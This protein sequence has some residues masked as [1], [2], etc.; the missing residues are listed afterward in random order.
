LPVNLQVMGSDPA[1][2]LSKRMKVT[3]TLGSVEMKRELPD[4]K[5]LR[6][7]EEGS[8]GYAV[9][10]RGTKVMTFVCAYSAGPL[11]EALPTSAETKTASGSRWE[12]HWST[13]GAIDLSASKD[14]RWKELE[15]RIVLSQFFFYSND[16]EPIHVHV[17]K[18]NGEAVFHCGR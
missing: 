16:Y 10:A 13:G 6:V 17:R 15:R 18:G 9:A 12:K 14:P 2:G 8:N 7:P 3:Y 11:P 4:G 5:A 1:I